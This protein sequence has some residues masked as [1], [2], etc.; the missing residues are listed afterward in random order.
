[1]HIA[2]GEDPAEH[3]RQ[4]SHNMCYYL[5]CSAVEYNRKYSRRCFLQEQLTR[6]LDY[7]VAQAIDD[8]VCRVRSS[9]SSQ[10]ETNSWSSGC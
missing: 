10:W 8:E 6:K 2:E 7:K 5:L 9:W 1:M 3:K 4:A